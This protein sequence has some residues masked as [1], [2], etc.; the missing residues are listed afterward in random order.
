MKRLERSPLYGSVVA[1]ALT[2][3]AL[4][5]SLLLRSHLEPGFFLLFEV[6]V[7]LSAWYYGLTAGLDRHRRPRPLRW[8]QSMRLPAARRW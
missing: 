4:L 3:V 2:A 1:L 5:L 8:A 7:W 6:A